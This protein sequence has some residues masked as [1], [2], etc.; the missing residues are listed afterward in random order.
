VSHPEAIEPVTT[1]KS[2]SAALILRARRTRKPV[3]ITQNGRPTAV[4]QDVESFDRQRR[5]LQLLMAIAEGD[6]D[7]RRGHTMSARTSE[8]RVQRLLARLTRA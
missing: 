2:K 5:A 4:L 6:R 7:Y 8:R 3:V 1:L